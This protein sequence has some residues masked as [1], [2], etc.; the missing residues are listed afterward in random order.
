MN[1][2]QWANAVYTPLKKAFQKKINH[3][4]PKPYYWSW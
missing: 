1:P 4:K 3:K 2:E